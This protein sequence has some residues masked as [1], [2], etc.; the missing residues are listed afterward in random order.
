MSANHECV[1]NPLA[2]LSNLSRFIEDELNRTY[3]YS[4]I[5]EASSNEIKRA[6]LIAIDLTRAIELAIAWQ[7]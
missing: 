5:T 3:G 6:K 4:G 7:R 1:T 2:V